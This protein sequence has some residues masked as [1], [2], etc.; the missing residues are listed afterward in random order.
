MYVTPDT[1]IYLYRNI[2][3]EPSYE[4]T[5]YFVS[6]V[7]QNNYFESQTVAELTFTKLSY[8][9]TLKGTLK[10]GAPYSRLYNCNYM[11]FQNSAYNTKWFYAFV[12][13]CEY[14][15]DNTTE[16]TYQIDVMQT[17]MGNYVMEQCFVERQHDST[18][19]YFGNLVPENVDLGSEYVINGTPVDVPM[20]HPRS[21]V[22]DIYILASEAIYDGAKQSNIVSGVYTPLYYYQYSTDRLDDLKACIQSFIDAGKE[23]SIVTIYQAP[24]YVSAEYNEDGLDYA[25]VS[26][27]EMLTT[28]DGYTPKN[29]KLFS[30]P[31]TFLQLSNHSGSVANYK[32][33][34]F[35]GESGEAMDFELARSD[36]PIPAVTC[37]PKHYLNTNTGAQSFPERAN[38]WD[39]GV[40]INNFPQCAWVGDTFKAWWAQNK[41]SVTTGLICN[42]LN[43]AVGG[44]GTSAVSK[45]VGMV[46]YSLSV[47]E[48][49]AK[50]VAKIQDIQAIPPNVHGYAQADGLLAGSYIALGFQFRQMC[51]SAKAAEI[52]DNYF[53]RFGYAI[54]MV[55]VPNR[56]ARKE[57][58]YVKTLG[59]A[60]YGP[61]P[62]EDKAAIQ[63]IFDN[64]ITFWN[65]PTHV[66]QFDLDNPPN[67]SELN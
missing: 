3:L 53:T 51:I 54:N 6:T 2:P 21:G 22:Y 8:Q 41:A 46:K 30:Y 64:G 50:V 35:R 55:K 23:D 9:R 27:P 36:M 39:Y 57:F 7:A 67:Y 16:V 44:I 1:T 17:W 28:I 59:C 45:D 42:V 26:A 66:G 19:A 56:N 14:I 65:D 62:A 58:T 40:V 13:H 48:N 12:M 60:I 63:N 25:P 38:G 18:D 31:Y 49:V 4:N 11:R 47:G 5:F 34:F 20:A 61:L 43:N 24:G 32:Y 33:E 52:I 37:Y 10:I 15:N 29:H